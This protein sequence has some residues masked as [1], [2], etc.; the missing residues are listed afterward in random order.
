[1]QSSNRLP[2]FFV[3]N[4]NSGNSKVD[5][6]QEITSYFNKK[7]TDIE[8]YELSGNN[9]EAVI[10]QK[11]KDLQPLMAVAVGG[12]GTVSLVTK[13]VMG[14]DVILGILP[15]G[16]ANGMAKELQ[17]AEDPLDAIKNLETGTVK[18]ADVIT[19]NGLP[20]LHLSD[21]GINAQLIKYF[22][23]NNMRGKLGY[24]MVLF[25]A[26]WR[27]QQ[28][29]INVTIN[30]ESF[31]RPAFMVV[32]ANASKYGTGAVINPKG[33][34][35]DGKFEVVIIKKIAL[36]EIFRMIFLGKN[37]N[38][39]KIEIISTEKVLITSRHRAHFQIDGEYLG[40]TKKIDAEIVQGCLQLIVPDQSLTNS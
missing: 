7:N 38:P 28:F 31:T 12:D 37:Y 33:S 6:K 17:I 30:G 40:K 36:S 34:L 16:S 22:E 27:R 32:I 24:A 35:Y 21:I 23:E 39:D 19:I 14:T 25:K 4:K 13:I 18:Q 11:L 15:A 8:L 29:K 1:M 9:D 2:F 5:W 26:L 3:I 20:C 10:K